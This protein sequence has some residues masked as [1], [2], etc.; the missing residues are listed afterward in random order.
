MPRPSVAVVR[1]AALLSE[2]EWPLK[3]PRFTRVEL[4][5][6]P[7][8]RVLAGAR[9]RGKGDAVRMHERVGM[10]VPMQ[11]EAYD[12]WEA[13]DERKHL[14]P[15]I[16]HVSKPDP[17]PRLLHLYL[18]CEHVGRSLAPSSRIA[19]HSSRAGWVHEQLVHE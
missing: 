12:S 13:F 8:H 3:K 4:Q 10:H 5:L 19:E 1:E 17:R 2:V 18:G 9:E 14:L 6:M 7:L 15:V 16:N 11:R